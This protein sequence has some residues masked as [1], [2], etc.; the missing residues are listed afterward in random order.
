MHTTTLRRTIVALAATLATG[1]AIAAADPVLV[2]ESRAAA[3]T[4]YAFA[5]E[6]RSLCVRF[7]VVVTERALEVGP[8]SRCPACRTKDL[9]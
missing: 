5:I 2:L 4:T 6:S 3:E 9:A 1:A 8:T 7:A